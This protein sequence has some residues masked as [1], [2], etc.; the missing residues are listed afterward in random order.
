MIWVLLISAILFTLFLAV[1]CLQAAQSSRFPTCKEYAPLS[2]IIAARNEG[3]HLQPHLEAVLSQSYPSDFEVLLVLDRCTDD[4]EKIA[5]EMQVKHSHLRIIG[6]SETPPDWAPKKWAV[7]QGIAAARHEYLAL[8][9]A[10]CLP[11]A[12]WL[13]AMGRQF[14]QGANLVLGLGPYEKAPGLLNALVRFETYVTAVLYMGLAR[15]GKP[16]MAVGRNLGYTKAF[17]EG[18][19]GFAGHQDRLSGDDDLLVNAAGKE[20]EI[21]LNTAYN[22]K[23]YSKAPGGWNQWWRQK[24]RHLSAGSAYSRESLFLLA[25]FHGLHAIFYISLVVVLCGTPLTGEAWAI[26]GFRTLLTLICLVLPANKWRFNAP[27]LWFPLLD[28]LYVLYNL[29]LVPASTFFQPKWE[30]K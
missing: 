18:A 14:S 17:F 2:V 16:Y 19:G 4:S 20:G 5:E 21:G 25:I 28:L 3:H 26:Y 27:L 11:E 13:K 6:I 9:D 24:I 30:H 8:T 23:T 29:I 12:G 7:H 1:L 22:G 15:M 10:D